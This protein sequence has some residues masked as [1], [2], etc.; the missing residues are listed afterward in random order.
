MLGDCKLSGGMLKSSLHG[1][2]HIVGA[3]KYSLNVT[4]GTNCNTLSVISCLNNQGSYYALGY[5]VNGEAVS[6]RM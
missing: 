4:E 6:L 5:K 2:L 3:S 1:A